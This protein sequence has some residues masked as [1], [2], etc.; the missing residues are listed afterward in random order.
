LTTVLITGASGFLGGRT[1]AFYANEL[2]GQY[3]VF[4]TSRSEGKKYLLENLGCTFYTGDLCDIN[5]VKKITKNIDIIIHCAAL[6][7]PYGPYQKFHR[8]NISAT[9]NIVN[10]AQQ[11]L[12]KK[13]IFIATPSIYVTNT[14]RF[15]VKE[16]DPLPAHFVNHYATTKYEAEK[17]VLAANSITLQTISLRPRAIIGAEDTV[18]FPRLFEA[19]KKGTLKIIGDGKNVCNLTCVQ[20]V[21]E[22]IRCAISAPESC[23]G[24]AYNITNDEI[25]NFWEVV[26]Y[27]FEKL[28]LEPVKKRVPKS[29]AFFVAG[30]IE[31]YYKLFKPHQEPS[32]T[33]YS[34]S[35]LADHFTLNI[36]KAKQNLHYKPVMTTKQGL[37]EFIHWYNQT[38]I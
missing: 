19:Y 13:L 36:E 24:S 6:S 8:S 20:N 30:L 18:I 31:S 2:S 17:I 26:N 37:D 5:F 3:Q 7:S 23:Y 28:S 34:I 9:Q 12:V 25:V 11:T 14:S 38:V 10:A 22:A 33:Q 29:I 27:T 21:I 15:N 1:A 4:A 35:V 16:S 32:L